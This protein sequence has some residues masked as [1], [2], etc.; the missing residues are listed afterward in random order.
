MSNWQANSGLIPAEEGN[1]LPVKPVER[2]LAGAVQAVSA[3]SPRT[4][5]PRGQSA[6]KMPSSM[7]CRDGAII[8][9]STAYTTPSHWARPLGHRT[10]CI[11]QLYSVLVEGAA[12]ATGSNAMPHFGQAPGLCRRTSGC[13]GHSYTAGLVL[14]ASA[15][16]N[17]SDRL[18]LNL[19]IQPWLQK[20]YVFRSYWT[21]PA[22][23]CLPPRPCR[24][25][26]RCNA[27]G[28]NRSSEKLPRA[29]G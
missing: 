8:I 24:S 21:V 3:I 29:A 10:G 2:A 26:W 12:I 23:R 16:F 20:A 17:E 1:G 6:L 27:A 28:Q 7:D 13:M 9:R 19:S 4:R 5:L 15:F 22:F 11:G 18:A 14:F 25:S